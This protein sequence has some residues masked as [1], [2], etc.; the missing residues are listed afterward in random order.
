MRR[1][2]LFSIPL[3]ILAMALFRFG[4]EAIGR[5]PDPLALAPNGGH[6]LPSWVVLATWALEALALSALYLLIYGRS[7]A[8]W[9]SGLLAGWI[10]WVFRGPLL[11]ITVVGV[12]GLPA[13][14]WWGMTVGWLVLYSFCGLLLG[15]S[16]AV[17]NLEP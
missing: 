6:E 5:A 7:G 14:A 16:A 8:R 4:L 3:L 2:L 9:T 11:V 17:S 10:A 13:A 15:G 1:F 12:A